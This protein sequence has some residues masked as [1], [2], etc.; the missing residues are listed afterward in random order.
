MFSKFFKTS[1]KK[2]IS[3]KPDL[4]KPS[5]SS[6]DATRLVALFL[7]HLFRTDKKLNHFESKWHDVITNIIA[8]YLKFIEYK[9]AIGKELSIKSDQKLG[10]MYI[11]D[12][13]MKSTLTLKQW[14]VDL[15]SMLLG[16]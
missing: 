12:N 13:Y 2:S 14:G 16:Q 15:M 8:N 6:T 4:R 1:S 7:S 11:L 10:D 3:C 5:L 9:Y